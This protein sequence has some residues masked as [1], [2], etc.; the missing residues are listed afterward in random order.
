MK[1]SKQQYG[2]FE[3]VEFLNEGGVVASFALIGSLFTLPIIVDKLVNL[4]PKMV[5]QVENYAKR[6][7]NAKSLIT[8]LKPVE[9]C[10]Y[11][12]DIKN[13]DIEV[14]DKIDDFCKYNRGIVSYIIKDKNNNIVA[15]SLFDPKY[16][17]GYFCKIV[18]DRY[19]GNT[20]ITNYIR[21][22]FEIVADGIGPGLNAIVGKDLKEFKYTNKAAEDG[23]ENS[24]EYDSNLIKEMKNIF[25]KLSEA[26][27]SEFK[28][29]KTSKYLEIQKD[30]QIYH[31]K[32]R[33]SKASFTTEIGYDYDHDDADQDSY[34]EH[35]I[36]AT[37]VV[38]KKAK[39]FG[40]S[41]EYNSND[42]SEVVLKS[43]KYELYMSCNRYISEFTIST[44]RSI[45][46][47]EKPD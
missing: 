28:K 44:I 23:D 42:A 25:N 22:K 39:S 13:K 16:K 41:R 8:Y 38:I 29:L 18:D 1:S 6:D 11:F 30:D 40:F 17:D 2:I 5:R 9:K 32:Y 37:D 7:S 46:A 4:P 36:D 33:N 35:Y 34:V 19:I 45:K 12:R 31:N 20:T 14:P 3:Q 26:F 15:Y 10:E 43:D 47:S 27:I 24:I 21:A